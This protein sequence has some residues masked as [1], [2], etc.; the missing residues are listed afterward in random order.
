[1]CNINLPSVQHDDDAEYPVH[2]DYN[3]DC[4]VQSPLIDFSVCSTGREAEKQLPLDIV[5]IL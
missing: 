4:D 1:M 2:N 3:D 5:L